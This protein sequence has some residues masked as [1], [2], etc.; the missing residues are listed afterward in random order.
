MIPAGRGMRPRNSVSKSPVP[1][2][3]LE[4]RLASGPDTRWRTPHWVFDRLPGNV[5]LVRGYFLPRGQHTPEGDEGSWVQGVSSADEIG[6]ALV[7]AGDPSTRLRSRRSSSLQPGLL[8]R[9]SRT[10]GPLSDTACWMGDRSAVPW[11]RQ[12]EEKQ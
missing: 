2:N 12:G 3:M 5:L 1:G 7:I 11:S 4:P 9:A 8:A 6:I 10:D